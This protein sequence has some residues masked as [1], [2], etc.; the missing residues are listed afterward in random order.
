MNLLSPPLPMLRVAAFHRFASIDDPAALA[1]R[2][3]AFG[4]ARTLRGSIILAA[5]GANGTIAKKSTAYARSRSFGEAI[6]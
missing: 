2:L 6:T 5:E 1:E 3:R 4:A